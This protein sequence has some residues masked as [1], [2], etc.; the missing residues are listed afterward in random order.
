VSLRYSL[1]AVSIALAVLA[2]GGLSAGLWRRQPPEPSAQPSPADEARGETS[3]DEACARSAAWIARRL[4]PPCQTLVHTPFVLAGDVDSARLEAAHAE[5]I[6]PLQRALAA[7]YRHARPPRPIVVLLLQSPDHFARLAEEFAGHP[8]AS[9]HGCYCPHLGLIVVNLSAGTSGLRHELVHALMAF[10][11]PAAPTWFSEGMA[12]L[13]ED[14]RLAG[15]GPAEPLISRRLTIL[16]EAIR[17]GELESVRSLLHLSEFGGP[18]QRLHYAHARFFCLHLHRRG[19]LA[20]FY[21]RFRDRAAADPSGV[22]T[23]SATLSAAP[24]PK[25]DADFR[26][27]ATGLSEEPRP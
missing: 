5:V 22:S 14:C 7:E 16:Q 23:L 25:I 3:L 13:Y 1:A 24:W 8:V 15:D 27:W 21:R 11:F 12:S 17:T 9:T 4:D 19:L 10:D 2:A 18:R 6:A 26:R 20:E